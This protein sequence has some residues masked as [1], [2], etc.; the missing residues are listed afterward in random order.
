MRTRT[1]LVLAAALAS[2]PSASFA[3]CDPLV[4]RYDESSWWW[5]AFGNCKGPGRSTDRNAIFDCAWN[6]VPAGERLACLKERLLRTEQTRKAIDDVAAANGP[7]GSCD[8]LMVKYDGSNWWWGAFGRCKQQGGTTDR[9]AIFECAWNQ[10]EGSDRRDCLKSRLRS[11]EFTRQGIDEVASFNGPPSSCDRLMVK[12]DRSAWWWGAFGNC[13]RT[14]GPVE[15]E[16]ILDCAW[17]QV[18]P[19]D[20][21]VCLKDRLRGTEQTRRGIDAV[22]A[23]NGVIARNFSFERFET[24]ADPA[25][26]CPETC[27][28]P[29]D[30]RV[31]TQYFGTRV[32]QELLDP[33][34]SSFNE[35]PAHN[36]GANEGRLRSDLRAVARL[37]D[38]LGCSLHLSA[39]QHGLGS[40]A[41]GQALAD[42]SVTGRR[43]FARFRS[44][45]PN[46]AY[47]SSL[48][49][50]TLA[51]ACPAPTGD[52]PDSEELKAG[53]RK[54][55]DRAYA[56]ANFLR[57][58]QAL[59]AN[60]DKLSERIVLGWIAVSGED[61][62]PHRPVNVPSSDFPQYDIDVA[63]P[64]PR[65]QPPGV[66]TVSTRFV[67]AQS[68]Q[69]ALPRVE[70]AGWTLR[71]E[72]PPA[73]GPN[74]KVLLLVHGMDSRAEE[75]TVITKALYSRMDDS[76][77]NLVVISVDL[78]TSGYADNL[79]YDRVS[80]LSAIGRPRFTF[81]PL[82]IPIPPE[83]YA[84]VVSAFVTLG[85]PPPPPVIPPWTPIPDF[86]ASGQTPV[87]D[88]IEDFI[89]RFVDA[90]DARTPIK[91]GV[92]AVIGGSLGGNMSFRLGRRPDVPWLPA[93]VVWSPASIW[94][95]LGEGADILKHLGP[96]EA[97]N[98][99][100]NRDPADPNDLGP[101]RLS[102]RRAFFDWDKDI[103]PLVIPR[104]QAETWSSDAWPCKLS[105][106]AAARLDR[107]ETYDPRFQSW[108]WRLGAEQLLYSHQSVDASTGAPRF[109]SNHKP[110]LLA[111]GTED[112]VPFNN[113]CS[114]TQKTAPRMT[115]TPG[116][117]IFL[118]RTGHSLDNERRDFF[119]RQIDEFL[120][121]R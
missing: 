77:T 93:V 107:H 89:V 10:V 103:V 84:A 36:L 1:I 72:P 33:P 4:V 40:G 67:V 87:L 73:I 90:L 20:D 59:K 53:C 26:G 85:L 31:P 54:A 63:V 115:A 116:K 96:R 24:C 100:N 121:L 7:A 58:G 39:I 66:V 45:P 120:G 75:A 91:N 65:A 78:P 23:A 86:A 102:L 38:P 11:T 30:G 17:L 71:P 82:P 118:E 18:E 57:T 111:C 64:A 76:K 47:C 88:F 44:D 32:P 61:D 12:Y 13:K 110:M 109:L 98:K 83:L 113:I 42:L 43:A 16:A 21:Q 48:P 74:A 25:S 119:A 97:W 62:A 2:L 35:P 56:V 19:P 108:H 104:S 80:P 70:P 14:G 114:A 46:E 99:A 37:A 28:L 92:R 29:T 79:D 55:L 49:T 52:Q 5:R 15:R 3:Q 101:R 69:P 106:I 22:A 60:P 105:S 50:R 95:S 27:D 51:S 6:Q 117:A 68:R 112:E 41:L 81:P 9:N 8:H 34:V 94:D